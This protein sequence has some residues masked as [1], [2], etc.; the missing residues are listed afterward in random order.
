MNSLLRP[1]KMAGGIFFPTCCFKVDEP[2]AVYRLR[3]CV[4]IARDF[5]VEE[6]CR[7]LK[8]GLKLSFSIKARIFFLTPAKMAGSEPSTKEGDPWRGKGGLVIMTKMV[9]SYT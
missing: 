5:L 8:L 1:F 7:F 3:T 9:M 6:N 2:F 4:S